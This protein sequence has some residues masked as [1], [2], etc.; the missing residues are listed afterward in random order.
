ADVLASFLQGLE[1][2]HN[3]QFAWSAHAVVEPQPD[4]VGE[5]TTSSPN[6][7]VVH[8]FTFLWF[9]QRN[10]V[11]WVLGGLVP[12]TKDHMPIFGLN[13]KLN[14]LGGR[15]HGVLQAIEVNCQA[16]VLLDPTGQLTAAFGF[17]QEGQTVAFFKLHA[18]IVAGLDVPLP[19]VRA[20][21]VT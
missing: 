8:R 6:Q 17:E 1:Q 16:V 12:N 15:V 14:A 20:L 2:V 13:R 3:S 5:S 19:T 9:P 10:R 21:R 7:S 11:N 18:T 4:Q